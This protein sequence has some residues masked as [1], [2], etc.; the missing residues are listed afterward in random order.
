MPCWADACVQR[1]KRLTPSIACRYMVA[2]AVHKNKKDIK[3]AV[4]GVLDVFYSKVRIT[5]S[6][7][8]AND[9]SGR[10]FINTV[11]PINATTRA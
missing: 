3:G 7:C 10:D 9:R 1:T 8:S 11:K 6:D 5:C 4:A 2:V